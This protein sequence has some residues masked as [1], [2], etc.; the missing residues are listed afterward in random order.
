MLTGASLGIRGSLVAVAMVGMASGARAD[1]FDWNGFFVGAHVDV[2]LS[3]LEFSSP[4]VFDWNGLGGSGWGAGII[5][6]YDHRLSERWVG[7]IEG[8]A[9]FVDET[10]SSHLFVP[11]GAGGY[12][13]LTDGWVTTDWAASLRARI[14][15]LVTPQTMFF[16][17]AGITAAHAKYG[18]Q[19]GISNTIV[20]AEETGDSYYGLLLAGIGA[21][22]RIAPNWRFRYEYDSTFL[23]T[24]S[25]DLGGTPLNVDPLGGTARLALIYDFDGMEKSPASF[26][27]AP[28][29]WTGAYFGGNV[30]PSMAVTNYSVSDPAGDV[31]NFDGNG[32]NGM[33]A[34]L[35][36]G[37]NFQLGS[38]MVLGL[39]G[40]IS[41]SSLET[42]FSVGTVPTN[43]SALDTTVDSTYGARLR[44]G[45]LPS[46]ATMIYGTVGWSQAHGTVTATATPP[47]VVNKTG[48]TVDGLEVGGGIEAWVSKYASVRADYSYVFV[49]PQDFV[50]GDPSLGTLK[51]NAAT[52]TIGLVFHIP[53]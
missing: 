26:G 45:Y 21:E 34:G 28:P 10:S 46:P 22:T 39:E 48:F 7:G 17:A 52:A 1:I 6:G 3:N 47:T 51:T 25:F 35:L 14:G 9:S 43:Y 41:T 37:Y 32:A 4:D 30:G 31:F 40:N 42:I 27:Y 8:D 13:L 20:S 5:G 12:S 50:P 2:G 44:F 33:A 24:V 11:D 49:D 16:A 53:Q 18:Y 29:T 38:K 15:Y 36:G 23:Q 19:V